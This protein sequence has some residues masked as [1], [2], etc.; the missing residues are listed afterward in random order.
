MKLPTTQAAL[1]KAIE[2][3]A[4]HAIRH[5]L[6]MEVAIE[7]YRRRAAERARREAEG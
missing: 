1:V 6:R 3:L 4:E 2:S 7:T 5:G